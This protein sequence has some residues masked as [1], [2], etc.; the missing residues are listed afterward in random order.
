LNSGAGQKKKK[1]PSLGERELMRGD[2][3]LPREGKKLS[4]WREAE[5]KRGPK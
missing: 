3:C 4:L 2:Y 5:Q 1:D